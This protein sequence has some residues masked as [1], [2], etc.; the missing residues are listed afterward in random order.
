M[1]AAADG[2]VWLL[3][4]EVATIVAA[5]AQVV[6]L[7]LQYRTTKR[8]VQESPSASVS[9]TQIV[10]INQVEAQRTPPTRYRG[11]PERAS[12]DDDEIWGQ[13]LIGAM[14]V[15]LVGLGYLQYRLQ[16]LSVLTAVLIIGVVCSTLQ[17]RM[18][19]AYRV[20]IGDEWNWLLRGG[21]SILALGAGLIA[22]LARDATPYGSYRE[23]R[24]IFRSEGWAGLTERFDEMSLILYLCSQFFSAL[25]LVAVVVMLVL[26]NGAVVSTINRVT[27]GRAP[28]W[29]GRTFGP[30]RT[31]W[32]TTQ[33]LS[34]AGAMILAI[35]VATP[36]FHRLIR[37]TSDIDITPTTTTT[38]SASLG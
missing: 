16:T 20:I 19:R 11:R 6:A 5:V 15:V 22:L 7:C 26:S 37:Q 1:L 9:W 29:F 34:L 13:V 27:R 10:T 24:R 17:L 23:L 28:S 8:T 12:T 18:L 35:I 2:S 32:Y 25:I 30:R 3:L 21:L 14:A 31:G 36:Q 38:T 4:V 33:T